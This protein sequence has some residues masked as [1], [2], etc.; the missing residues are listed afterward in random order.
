[1]KD[2]ENVIID[3]D[4]IVKENSGKSVTISISAT[5]ACSGCHARGT[6]STFGSE[7][8]IIE[9]NGSYNVKPGETVTVR[10]M[11]SMGFRALILGYVLPF[12]SVVTVLV[13]LISLDFTELTAGLISLGVLLPYYFILFL[14]RK[15]INEKFTFTLKV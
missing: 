8:K 7:E 6:C 14:F 12:I 13:A 3:H 15:R 4:G 10:M 2:P 5:S 11:Q 9:V 1:M